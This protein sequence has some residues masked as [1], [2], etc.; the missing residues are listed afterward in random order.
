MSCILHELQIF[1]NVL[2]YKIKIFEDFYY[3]NKFNYL[4]ITIYIYVYIY[5]TTYIN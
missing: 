2:P 3:I 4:D 1:L 5:F